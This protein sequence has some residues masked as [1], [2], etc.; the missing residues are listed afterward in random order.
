MKPLVSILIPAYNAERWVA[1]AIQSA[2]AQSW[3]RKEIIVVDDGSTDHTADEVRRFLPN[4]TLVCGE[5][6][7]ASA[8]RN[9][10]LQL[11]HGDFIQWLDADDVLM[12]DKI[13]RQLEA[14]RQGESK[15]LLLSSSWAPIHYRTRNAQFVQNSLCQDLS[16][17]EWLMRK[18]NENLH[19][20]TATWLVSRELTEAAG[21]WDVRLS[22]DDDG[23][24]FARVLKS[25]AG[26]HFVAG[27]GVF[28]RVPNVS[29]L[30]HIGNS[31]IKKDSMFLSIKLHIQYT[32]S[33]EESERVRNACMRY[34]QNWYHHFYP[35]RPDI[36]ADLQ[37]LAAELDGHL[38]EP[39]LRSRFTS[40][41]KVA[42]P[43]I[44][45]KAQEVLPILK[46]SVLRHIDRVGLRLENFKGVV[47]SATPH[48]IDLT[49]NGRLAS[50][51]WGELGSYNRQGSNL[52]VQEQ[53]PK[54]II[55][56]GKTADLP[57][58]AKAVVANV[59]LLNPD[60]EYLFFDNA[61][62]EQFIDAEFPEYRSI[63]DSFKYPIQKYDFFRYLAVYRYG[64]FYFD[65]DVLLASNLMPLLEHGCVFSFEALTVSRLLRVDLGMDWIIGN[66]A[67]GAAAGHP[68]LKAI[69][70]NCVKAQL[71]PDW[72]KP[73]MRGRPPFLNDEFV[74]LNTTGPGLVSRTFAEN[75]EFIRTV[76]ILFPQ[77]RADLENWNRFGEYGI[78][79][80]DSS[81]RPKRGFLRRKA[82]DF[83]WRWV[84][85]RNIKR[86][87]RASTQMKGFTLAVKYDFKRQ[88]SSQ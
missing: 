81:W 26:T 53:I 45:W 56:T 87:G 63:F 13:E 32:R 16:P 36:V 1:E 65:V 3:P 46:A 15:H 51:E 24:Y 22:A 27:T 76:K 14:I 86:S 20:Q 70:D 71:D 77:D 80:A 29:S 7:G 52:V 47:D 9:H 43:R 50:N 60:F 33:L 58:R 4:V 35:S 31:D 41:R 62:V 83:S 25:S 23:E 39:V 40:I 18:M 82:A 28:Y 21:D 75:P 42:G 69:I 79:L 19:M 48:A 17:V 64:G 55:Q 61:Q 72:A 11:S 44:A 59:K 8:A 34:M 68:F 5:N 66:Y 38:Q 84:Q 30:S 12:T 37:N 57:L 54:R 10:A 78:H 2:I 6:R 49:S 74:V 88:S 85:R 73:M 67:F